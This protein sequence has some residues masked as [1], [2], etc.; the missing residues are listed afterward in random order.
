MKHSTKV[1]A[2]KYLLAATSLLPA[3]GVARAQSNSSPL[4]FVL[5][6]GFV[7]MLPNLSSDARIGKKEKIGFNG[8]AF[9]EFGGARWDRLPHSGV[10][11]HM[12]PVGRIDFLMYNTCI[13]GINADYSIANAESKSYLPKPTDAYP[14][15]RVGDL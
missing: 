10:E 4:D 7:Y 11:F 9:V 5:R 1:V 12:E 8:G 6:A 2:S 13:Y 3:V 15:E 14:Y